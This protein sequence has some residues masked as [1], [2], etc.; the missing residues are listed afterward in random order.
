MDLLMHSSSRV[1]VFI[2]QS[3]RVQYIDP[4]FNLFPVYRLNSRRRRRD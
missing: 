4:D 2:G 3:D 1:R